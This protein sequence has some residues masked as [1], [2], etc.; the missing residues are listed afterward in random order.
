MS[1]REAGLAPPGVG[2]QVCTWTPETQHGRH[3]LWGPPGLG[4]GRTGVVPLLSAPS[5]PSS[6][7]GSRK[8]LR[9][10]PAPLRLPPF[11]S[12]LLPPLPAA[13]SL[14]RPPPPP[15]SAAAAPSPPAPASPR[16]F[17]SKRVPAHC[18]R[19]ATSGALGVAGRGPGAR[20][21][22][23]TTKVQVA[24][25]VSGTQSPG[26][27]ACL[28]DRRAAAVSVGDTAAG[29][30]QERREP[31][32]TRSSGSERLGWGLR[33]PWGGAAPLSRSRRQSASL[34]GC[35]APPRAATS[36]PPAVVVAT[37]PRLTGP[38][39]VSAAAGRVGLAGP[40]GQPRLPRAPGA[41]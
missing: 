31:G 28:S 7:P 19:L 18:L 29:R 8:G 15:P 27:A 10:L 23:V 39:S 21:R 26:Q 32:R 20:L 33:G 35:G 6:G 3:G 41:E 37:A 25:A 13:S 16:H 9:A 38:P 5:A 40:R 30:G 36:L 24:S 11:P 14:L 1:A 17:V 34:L 4:S 22:G 2:G 12:A